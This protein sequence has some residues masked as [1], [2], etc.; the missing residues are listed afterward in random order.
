MGI[1][2][3]TENNEDV[4]LHGFFVKELKNR[5]L[6]EIEIDGNLEVCYVPS[7]CKL[8]RLIDL[9]GRETLLL[10]VKK[11][12]ARTK[13]SVYAVKA[14][15]NYILLNLGECNAILEKEIYRRYFSF[16]GKRTKLFREA[17]IA[18]YKADLFIEDTNTIIEVKSVLSNEKRAMFP[19]VHSRRALLQLEKISMLLEDGYSVCYVF[20]S[21]N[22]KTKVLYIDETNNEYCKLFR[23]CVSKGMQCCAVS[24]GFKDYQAKVLA[25]LKVEL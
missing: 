12:D 3:K 1:I 19:S 8:S 25:K 6:A 18:G 5:F 10:P 2:E 14:G 15:A 11:K 13:Y 4:F 7:S 16:L 23:E 9:S 24:I 17:N 20:A 22:P 21:V